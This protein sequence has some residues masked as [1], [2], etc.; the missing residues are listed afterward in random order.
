MTTYLKCIK[1][2]SS[3]S[4]IADLMLLITL[5]HLTCCT[6]IFSRDKLIVIIGLAY[7]GE[8]SLWKSGL[9]QRQQLFFYIYSGG[10]KVS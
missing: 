8:I 1:F 4:A 6:V 10:C 7:F 2:K 5:H 9:S 3:Y